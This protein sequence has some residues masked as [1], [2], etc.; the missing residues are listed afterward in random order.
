MMRSSVRGREQHQDETP[1]TLTLSTRTS[2][3]SVTEQWRPRVISNGA[4]RPS[5]VCRR[6]T[7]PTIVP[8]AQVAK[9]WRPGTSTTAAFRLLYAWYTDFSSAVH[10]LST[11]LNLA[12]MSHTDAKP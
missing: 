6:H 8:T 1:A 11:G 2:D 12:L 5:A 4:R 7:A 9:Q 10:T 3:S